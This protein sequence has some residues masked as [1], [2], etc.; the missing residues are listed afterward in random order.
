M[1][2]INTSSDLNEK[3]YDAIV[4]VSDGINSL[5]KVDKFSADLRNA[6]EAYSKIDH[7]L[8]KGKVSLI[9]ADK[10]HAKRIV[11]ASTG[12]V[13]KDFDDVRRY[14]K[15]GIAAGETA[16]S[17]GVRS[18]LLV[19]VPSER[20][21]NASLMAALG[22]LHTLYTPL[23]LAV[24]DKPIRKVDLLGIFEVEANEKSNGGP[25]AS[26]L[27]ALQQSFNVARDIGDGDPERMCPAKVAEYVKKTFENSS[28]RVSIIDD[29]DQIRRDYPLLSAVSRCANAIEEH[30]ARLIW[31]EYD[32]GEETETLFLVGKGVTLDTGGV[33]L[34]VN[35]A[36]L[37]MSRDKYGSAVVAGFFRALDE[38]KP[39]G[40]K[41]VGCMC[42][43]R[44]SIGSHAYT[45]DEIITSRSGKRVHIYNTD[46]EGR[47]AMAD[48]LAEAKEKAMKAKNP[49]LFTIAT[50]TGHLVLT[51][52]HCSA[53]MDNGPAKA[54][55]YAEQL[56][57]MGDQF[58]QPV[59]VSRLFSEDFDFHS[60]KC[61]AA[62]LMQANALPSVRTPRGHMGPAAFLMRVSRIDEAGLD[63]AQPL[64]YTH[65][66]IGISMGEYPNTSFPSPLL[67]LIAQ[68]VLPK[69]K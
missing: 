69:V 4:V 52:G 54:A 57:K 66:D 43:C 34:K 48:P 8:D 21:P 6:V 27:Q 37:G 29:V 68:H 56:R 15:A 31:L 20:F 58:G 46:A 17:A 35:G 40:I 32:G 12:T 50:L 65:L 61:E 30:K 64:K 62:D 60:A 39:K 16:L 47:M 45:C 1:I 11:Y 26:L 10:F 44:N 41:V 24:P 63:S 51:Y 28:V 22:F 23:N 7:S 53:A 25:S 18:P 55:N 5:S 19:A 36:M 14:T 3:V 38:L 67:A 49:H 2:Q 42:M 59:E 9:Q 13:H 33:D